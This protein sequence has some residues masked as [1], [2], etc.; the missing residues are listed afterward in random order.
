MILWEKIYLSVA[1]GF[2][3]DQLIAEILCFLKK[4]IL[5]H[6]LYG[7]RG[8][9]DPL[10]K[11]KRHEGFIGS[12]QSPLK[13]VFQHKNVWWGD[14]IFAMLFC[15]FFC[16]CIFF[17]WVLRWCKS[18]AK[19]LCEQKGDIT[20]NTRGYGL[21]GST[22]MLCV[23]HKHEEKARMVFNITG[24]WHNSLPWENFFQDKH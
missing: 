18:I 20:W 5:V 16:H 9:L 15:I 1:S 24:P 17:P 13:H 8:L 23:V 11:T 4:W 10:I 22:C 21:S 14:W 2:C 19:S 3:F 7:L 6:D 12:S